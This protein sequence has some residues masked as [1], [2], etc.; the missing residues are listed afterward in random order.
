MLDIKARASFHRGN[1][2]ELVP[3]VTNPWQASTATGAPLRVD[4][5]V[6]GRGPSA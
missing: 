2:T 1:T 3:H 5:E 6:A 4:Q